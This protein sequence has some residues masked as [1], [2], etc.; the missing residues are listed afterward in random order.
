MG[1]GSNEKTIDIEA[2]SRSSI[3]LMNC[4]LASGAAM[5][6]MDQG[7][8][9]IRLTDRTAERSRVTD[10]AELPGHRQ[11]AVVG[12]SPGTDADRAEYMT[13]EFTRLA[14]YAALCPAGQWR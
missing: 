1:E 12:G 5:A 3:A 11:Q 14:S 4:V 2:G 9:L 7:P 8:R 10:R 13:D 6:Q